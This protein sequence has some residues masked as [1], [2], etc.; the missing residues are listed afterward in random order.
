MTKQSISAEK[1]RF[2]LNMICDPDTAAERGEDVLICNK[3]LENE[4]FTPTP[5]KRDWQARY[6]KLE[7]QFYDLYNHIQCLE[8]MLGD[9]VVAIEDRQLKDALAGMV[10]AMHDKGREICATIER[11]TD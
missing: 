11:S 4:S 7:V 10:Y 5:D 6:E 2:N 8:W 9:L 3:E 1:P